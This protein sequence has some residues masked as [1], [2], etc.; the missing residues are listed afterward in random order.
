M[1]E[2]LQGL[3]TDI[4]AIKKNTNQGNSGNGKCEKARRNNRY[5]SNK[6]QEM[7]ER[8]SGTEDMMEEIDSSVK[9]NVKS[10][11]FLTQNIQEIW[12]A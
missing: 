10:N 4:E 7:E 5:I 8:I 3:K 9:E 11:E 12:Y 6:T 2:M 1:K